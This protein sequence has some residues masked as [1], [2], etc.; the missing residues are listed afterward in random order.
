[1]NLFTR[2]IASLSL[3]TV[4]GLAWPSSA[5]AQE[6]VVSG[7]AFVIHADRTLAHLYGTFEGTSNHMRIFLAGGP[8]ALSIDPN[9][10]VNEEG[11]LFRYTMY[12]T[13][14]FGGDW[15][16]VT[17]GGDFTFIDITDIGGTVGIEVEIQGTWVAG[18]DGQP[19]PDPMAPIRVLIVPDAI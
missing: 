4:A 6:E 14:G 15:G 3:L 5:S 12:D 17:G 19:I 9:A 10:P 18:A 16:T 7:T 13:G 2:A 1:M 8:H 11:T